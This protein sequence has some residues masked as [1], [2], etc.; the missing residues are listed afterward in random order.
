MKQKVQS[1]KRYIPS[2]D[3]LRTLAVFAVILYHLN[4]PGSQ[5]GL[6]GV[7]VFFVLSGYLITGILINE[8]ETS[9]SIK[10]LKFWLRRI[11]RLFP[12]IVFVVLI[13]AC[14]CIFINHPLLTKMKPDIIPGLFWFENWWYVIRDM[15]YFEAL[16]DPSPLTHFWS[17][18][19]EEQFYLVWPI[20]L[21]I[22]FKLGGNKKI[23][24]ILCL[25]LAA[26][27]AG[28]MAFLYD[29]LIDPTR[30]Y[31]GTDTRAFSLLIGGWLS[32]VWPGITFTENRTQTV[33][34]KSIAIF[35]IVAFIALLGLLA[36][37]IFVEGTSAFMYRGGIV[38]AS[39]LT[40][41][42]IANL[43]HPRTLLSKIFSFYPLVWLGKRSYAMYL[44]HFPIILLLKPL[45]RLEGGYPWWFVLLAIAL[46]ILISAI[47][48]TFV[49]EPIRKG[50]LKQLFSRKSTKQRQKT[51]KNNTNNAEYKGRHLQENGPE[52]N[53]AHRT[54]NAQYTGRYLEHNNIGHSREHLKR[55]NPE[56]GRQDIERNIEYGRQDIERNT[57]NPKKEKQGFIGSKLHMIILLALCTVLAG[58]TVVGCIVVP[59]DYLVPENAINST[60]AGVET[61]IILDYNGNPVD[62]T[63]QVSAIVALRTDIENMI[64]A[65]IAAQKK[66]AEEARLKKLKYPLMIGDS[67]P[68]DTER[69]FGPKFP[70]G[71]NDS[72][73]NRS[74]EAALKVFNGYDQQGVA[75]D[76]I[77]F[78]C[79][80]N[81]RLNPGMLDKMLE[82]V[83]PNR[84]MFL[85][86]T[87]LP[88]AHCETN[89]KDIADFCRAHDNVHLVDWYATVVDHKKQ[90]L[91]DDMTHLRPEGSTA[92]IDLIYNAVKDYLPN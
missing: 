44:W 22:I 27:S 28:L 81:F 32:I 35:D 80:T 41:V 13:V 52:Y 65:E 34:R 18:A 26:I 76:I 12:A 38:I 15:S 29:P 67:V 45:V 48:F 3:G 1:A 25:I 69:D 37:M 91:W 47:S 30:V 50:A 74:P 9:G 6:L 78:A 71:L 90:Y 10:L 7:T 86:N 36:M 21:L 66:A 20:I 24:R 68:G 72:V 40:A 4:V 5:G 51:D 33:S 2:L 43:V 87:F 19:I 23:V 88:E 64:A 59:D 75:G 83:G 60:G 77:V 85:V 84:H 53:L 14:F 46:T 82:A 70:H 55:N 17:L 62:T 73:K 16:G 39:I 54:N 58:V 31:Y 8:F 56:Y 92:Y 42:I 57:P 89:N 79:F 63:D 61:A 11:R 49:E